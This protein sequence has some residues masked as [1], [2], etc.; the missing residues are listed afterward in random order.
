MLRRNGRINPALRNAYLQSI[1]NFYVVTGMAP[2]VRELAEMMGGR[3][4]QTVHNMLWAL[5]E[6]GFVSWEAGRARTLRV[7]DP[8]RRY[9]D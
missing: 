8:G 6:D 2:T 3:S 7:L 5:R 1:E 9:D 4:T